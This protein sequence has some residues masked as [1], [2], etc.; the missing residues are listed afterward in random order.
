MINGS[1]LNTYH[2]DKNIFFGKT[3]K[4]LSIS[5]SEVS[6]DHHSVVHPKKGG[7]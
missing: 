6:Y 1:K 4:S 7:R 3:S 5:L 2:S